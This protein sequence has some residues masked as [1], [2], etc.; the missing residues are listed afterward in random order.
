MGAGSHRSCCR[1]TRHLSP[2]S[3][4]SLA[5]VA[6]DLAGKRSRDLPYHIWEQGAV[7]RLTASVR[8]PLV[9]TT[10]L[11]WTRRV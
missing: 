7:R 4:R 3:I 10:V 2:V 1:A 9:M 6:N 8:F 11:L 5:P